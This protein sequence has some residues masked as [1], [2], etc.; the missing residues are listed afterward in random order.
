M[1]YGVFDEASRDHEAEAAMRRHAMVRTAVAEEVMPFLALAGSEREYEHRKALA[2]DHLQRIA[3]KYDVPLA[4]VTAL[5]DRVF[6]LMYRSRTAGLQRTSSTTCAAC[7]HRNTDHSEGLRCPCGC[8][9]F[10]PE[11]QE[12]EA[13]VY[14]DPAKTAAFLLANPGSSLDPSTDAAYVKQVEAHM[15]RKEGRRVTAEEGDG[16]F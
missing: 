11:T 16:P 2:E 6:N 8:T 10:Q 9:S 7:G 5:A 3:D 15:R 1:D 12:K 13:K 14:A 4:D